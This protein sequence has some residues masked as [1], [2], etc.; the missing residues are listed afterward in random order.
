M[1][2]DAQGVRGRPSPPRTDGE[3]NQ[4]P[5]RP[6]KQLPSLF[7]TDEVD[8][9]SG[10]PTA[11]TLSFSLRRNE[12]PVKRRHELAVREPREKFRCVLLLQQTNRGAHRV[13]LFGASQSLAGYGMSTSFTRET[14]VRA[15]TYEG[16]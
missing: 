6:Q 5:S 3:W 12:T 2:A 9:R 15:A 7:A 1:I 8:E 4:R 13:L 11:A 10:L 14:V 16:S